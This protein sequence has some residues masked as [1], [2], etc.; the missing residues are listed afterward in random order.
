M[1]YYDQAGSIRYSSCVLLLYA[2]MTAIVYIRLLVLTPHLSTLDVVACF[3]IE[4]SVCLQRHPHFAP[5]PLKG[6]LAKKWKS[7][8]SE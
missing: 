4:K 3:L 2:P 1:L 5:V 8:N 7:G 6:G